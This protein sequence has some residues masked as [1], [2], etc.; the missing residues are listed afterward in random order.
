M[1]TEPEAKAL[2]RAHG[3][4]VPAGRVVRAA[5]KAAAPLPRRSGRRSSSR[6]CAPN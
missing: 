1:L 4:P 3:I 2:L 6:R 5:E